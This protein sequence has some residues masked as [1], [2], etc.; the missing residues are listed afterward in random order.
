[1]TS[2][3]GLDDKVIYLVLFTSGNYTRL[4]TNPSAVKSYLKFTAAHFKCF[5]RPI[6]RVGSALN[7]P[8]G[9]GCQRGRLDPHPPPAR[10]FFLYRVFF[11]IFQVLTPPPPP[12]LVHIRRNR[13]SVGYRL[14]TG[15]FKQYLHWVRSSW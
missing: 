13:P 6:E 4:Q 15:L 3:V 9:K 7:R 2:D 10:D 14:L 8:V 1:M 5:L 12:F 11:A